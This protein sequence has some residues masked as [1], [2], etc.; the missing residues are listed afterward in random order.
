MQHTEA[1]FQT[2]DQ[3]D[4][5]YQ[6]WQP[7]EAKAALVIMHGL[8]EHSGRYTT[9]VN[10]LVPK[11]YALYSMDNRGHGRSPGKRGHIADWSV[12]R[13][14]TRTFVELVQ[15]KENGRPFFLLGHS[16]GGC[17]VLDYAL[18]Y[19][20]GLTAVVA[21]A[22]AIGKLKVPPV[23]LTIS[24]LLAKIK[25][26]LGIATGLDANGISRD[27][28]E[29]EKYKNDPLVH[30]MGTPGW[31]VSFSETAVWVMA[32]AAEFHPPLLMLNGDADP[33]VDVNETRRFFEQVRQPDKKLVIYEGGYHESHHDLHQEQ[34]LADLEN[35]LE[36]HLNSSKE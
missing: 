1:T 33:I 25:P 14:D 24:K 34:M 31:L 23:M 18:H 3:T 9:V 16:M 2:H 21:S 32:H 22:P 4:M 15:E 26:D 10:H 35:W 20:G 11:G 13:E 17:I 6:T 30:G 12:F 27:P 7:A 8:G 36:V 28:A 19:P 5:F 29:V